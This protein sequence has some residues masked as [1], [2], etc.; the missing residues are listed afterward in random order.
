MLAEAATAG[1]Y[2]SDVWQRDYPRVQIRPPRPW[3]SCWRGLE[4]E[5]P[6]HPSMYQAAQRERPSEGEQPSPPAHGDVTPGVYTHAP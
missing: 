4:F 6:R 3:G 5:A 1:F 2:H